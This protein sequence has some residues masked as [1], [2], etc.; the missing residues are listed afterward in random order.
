[1]LGN[2]GRG[3][4]DDLF[5]LESGRFEP[6]PGLVGEDSGSFDLHQVRVLVLDS[7]ISGGFGYQIVMLML[8]HMGQIP[9]AV[10]VKTTDGAVP[11]NS[12]D[13]LLDRLDQAADVLG[14]LIYA[15]ADSKPVGPVIDDD[16]HLVEI[17]VDLARS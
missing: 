15:E 8:S 13:C 14:V 7:G 10:G 3:P 5:G 2:V 9:A 4:V 16:A 17:G 6:W 1:M 11:Q 12:I